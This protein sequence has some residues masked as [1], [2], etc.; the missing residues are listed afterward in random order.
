MKHRVLMQFALAAVLFFTSGFAPALHATE[1][2]GQQRAEDAGQNLVGTPAARLTVTTIDG[3]QIDLGQLYGKKAVYLKFWATW[4]QPCREQM[5]HFEHVYDT[6]GPD[7][8]VIAVNI[9]F[10]DSAEDVRA[11]RD[12]YH[13]RM[14]IVI[15]DGRLANAFHL[16]VTPQHVVIGRDGKISYV[17][18]FADQRLQDAL[19]AASVPAVHA[20]MVNP[21]F[22]AGERYGIGDQLP[23]LTATTLEG[24]PYPIHDSSAN[25][26]TALVFLS[27]WCESYLAT[28]RPQSAAQCRQVREQVDTL[29]KRLSQVRWLGVASGIWATADDL[30]AYRS[31]Y[32]PEIPLTLDK[33]GVWFRTFEV[34]SVPTIVL[35]DRNGRVSRRVQGYSADLPQI[36]AA[37]MRG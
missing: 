24:K 34:T 10:N 4:C 6:A 32:K 19:A 29:S 20:P 36:L 30:T 35:I 37:A 21:T 26:V 31:Q 22:V 28:T 1:L 3:E 7:L 14:P 17:G 13:L 8:A 18:W 5:P 2:S 15:D 23:K 25:T 12:K 33:S 16:R 9:G 11:F 27:P